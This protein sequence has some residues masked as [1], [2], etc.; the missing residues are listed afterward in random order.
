MSKRQVANIFL[1]QS[2]LASVNLSPLLAISEYKSIRDG[3]VKADFYNDCAMIPDPAGLNVE[4][5]DLHI[6]DDCFLGKQNKAEAYYTRGRH[7]NCGTFYISQNYFRI[8]RQT[9][10]ENANLI[11]LSSRDAKNL[12]HI[13]ADHCDADMSTEVY[14][15]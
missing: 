7:T 2:I 6:L 9:I 15:R 5:K 14:G 10:R 1:H 11:I 3:S 8:L 4:E 12:N 13:H